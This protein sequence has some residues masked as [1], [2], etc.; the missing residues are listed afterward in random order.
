MSSVNFIKTCYNSQ[1]KSLVDNYLANLECDYPDI[2]IILMGLDVEPPIAVTGIAFDYEETI[3]GLDD[4][5]FYTV[6]KPVISPSNATN[7][8]ITYV[9]F[10]QTII[11]IPSESE[12]YHPKKA[13]IVTITAISEDGNFTDTIRIHVVEGQSGAWDSITVPQSNL[14]TRGNLTD[15]ILCYV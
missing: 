15:K 6:E 12:W 8:K 14:E 4:P 13:G 1:K 9:S 3:I 5:L 2:Y 7:Q 11:D 10:D